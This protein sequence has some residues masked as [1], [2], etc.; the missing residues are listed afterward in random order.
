[1]NLAE[2]DQQT[3]PTVPLIDYPRSDERPDEMVD[4]NG[5]ARPHWSELIDAL[6][7]L[8]PDEFRRRWERGQRLI[9]DHGIVDPSS[10]DEADRPLRLDPMPLMIDPAEWAVIERGME[11][12]S[13][14]LNALLNDVY[15]EGR[16]AA[17]GLL[18][19]ALVHGHPRFLRPCRGVV[20]PG[21]MYLHL[22]AGDLARAGD[23]GSWLVVGDRTEAPA[24]AGCVVENRLIVSRILAEF[25]GSRRVRRLT[26]FFDGFRDSLLSL[27]ARRFET[28]KFT[29]LT[30]GP[31]ADT[32]F[33][34]A[35]LSRLLGATLVESEDLT[36]RDDQVFL[37]TLDGLQRVDVILRQ[38]EGGMCD[39]LEFDSGSLL[40]VAGLARAA[41]AG[42]VAIANALGSGVVETPAL[43]GYLP[44]LSR[45]LLG[46]ELILQSPRTWWCGDEAA[47]REVLGRLGRLVVRS[48]F[49]QRA[50][51]VHG[52]RLS[53]R[54]LAT[55]AERI[56]R[57]PH[58]FTARE[59]AVPST[60]PVWV[61][62]RLKPRPMVLRVF[63][64]IRDGRHAP[65]PGALART[66]EGGDPTTTTLRD[67]AGGGKDTWIPS[68]ETGEERETPDD[69]GGPIRLTRGGRDLPSRVADNMFWLGRYMERCEDITRVLRV[70]YARAEDGAAAGLSHA[71]GPL[72]G[73][74][75]QLGVAANGRGPLSP[76][77][78]AGALGRRHFDP[79]QST[80]LVADIDRLRRVA[81]RVRDRLSVDTWRNVRLLGELA[82]EKLRPDRAHDAGEA[83][84]ALSDVIL[85]LEAASGLVMENMTRGLGWR[86]LDIGRRVERATQVVELLSA[87]VDTRA[88][89]TA[90]TLDLLLTILDSGMTYRSRYF[91][92]PRL[93]PVLDLLLCDESNPR[94]VAYQLAALREHVERLS[95][96]RDTARIRPEQRL[97]VYLESLV[98]TV[99]VD[100]L[101]ASDDDGRR[102]ELDKL[103]GVVGGRLWELTEVLTREYFTHAVGRA[104]MTSREI[105]L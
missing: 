39:P 8:P 104:V 84:A 94:S 31:G 63:L 92:A 57:R 45:R 79:A 2:M 76:T 102:H 103:L 98:R 54:E 66:A 96:F 25:F 100:A 58:A 6:N 99:D 61:D 85:T 60:T 46:E 70:V 67:S 83:Q 24:G 5:R 53:R 65:M 47:R 38:T 36:V 88:G 28:P 48:T 72:M 26:P 42:N 90:T 3:R 69:A 91:P 7:A 81:G 71:S 101:A 29:L 19:P 11:Q 50:A 32:Y 20:P 18:P 86:F 43:A 95:A 75:T 12:R 89:E 105:A 37:K 68:I 78:A 97:M 41:R 16:T 56:E 64:G 23:D 34:H 59:P 44:A 15:G 82:R 49:N 77:E 35:Y 80:G 17:E 4:A 30:P 87:A 14:L 1:M 52:D 13:R 21:G 74:V 9:A 33:E 55:L 62:G 10:G 22:L 51:A 93:V 40:G 27:S 73:I